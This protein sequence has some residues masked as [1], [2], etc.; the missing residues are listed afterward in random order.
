M[1]DTDMFEHA[2]RNDSVV[3]PE[4][5]AVIAQVES[6]AIGKPCCRCAVHCHLVLLNREGETSHVGAA[7]AREVERETTPARADVEHPLSWPDQQ[8]GRNVA[9]LVELSAVE[10]VGGITEVSAGILKVLI[11][12]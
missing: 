11:E 12:E 2:D 4:F 6:D 3:M 5:L 8:L 7:F 10:V 1:I 9:L